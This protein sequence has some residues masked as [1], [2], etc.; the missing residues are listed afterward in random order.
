[1]HCSPTFFVGK[2]IPKLRLWGDLHFNPIKEMKEFRK[3]MGGGEKVLG[4]KVW[5]LGGVGG[6][7]GGLNRRWGNDRWIIS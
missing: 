1:M 7:N 3:E 2:L 6:L 5:W 4:E